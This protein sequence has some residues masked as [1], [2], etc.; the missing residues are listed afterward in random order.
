MYEYEFFF[1]ALV[2]IKKKKKTYS[3]FL[4]NRDGDID[5]RSEK[6]KAGDRMRD[7]EAPH[8]QRCCSYSLFPGAVMGR[9]KKEIRFISV[10]PKLLVGILYIVGITDKLYSSSYINIYII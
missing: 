10:F 4:S 3:F 5:N 8:D 1:F 9:R 7:N 2:F 6:K